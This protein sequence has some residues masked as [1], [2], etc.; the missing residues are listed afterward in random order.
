MS[1]NTTSPQA[2]DATTELP[3]DVLAQFAIGAAADRWKARRERA[4]SF[5]APA[6]LLLVWELASRSALIDQQFFPAPSRIARGA[7]TLLAN[8]ELLDHTQASVGRVL[9][10]FVIGA[11]PAVILGVLM[12]Y[13]TPLRLA[14]APIVNALYPVPKSAIAPLMLLMFGFGEASKW[15]LVAIGVFFPVI[16]NTAAGVAQIDRTF[17][18][19]GRSFG[20]GRLQMFWTVALPGAL[21]PIMTGLKLG[22]GMGMILVAIAEMVGARSGLGYLIWNSWQTFSVASMY[23]GL[24][25]IAILGV[26]FT[27]AIE[28]VE[29]WIAPWNR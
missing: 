18:Q 23:V 27:Y 29:R 6:A 25:T 3:S 17:Y 24:A 15:V 9:I 2:T 11:V 1:A 22:M 8:G 4:I 19:V 21:P 26:V 28:L 13:I 16:L 7:W 10:G 5:L 20:A 14:L 12:G